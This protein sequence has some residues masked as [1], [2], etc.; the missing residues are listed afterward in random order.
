[1]SSLLRAPT[2]ETDAPA[3]RSLLPSTATPSLAPSVDQGGFGAYG[4][5]GLL[6]NAGV[7]EAIQ[8][9]RAPK[10]PKVDPV[11][12]DRK[13]AATELGDR[14]EVVADDHE[15]ERLSN[16]VTAAEYA[17]ICAV[18]SDV[19]LGRGD[20][21]IDASKYT[22]GKDQDAYK[23]GA[24]GDIASLLQTESGR[25]L[26]YA[27][28]DN[29]TQTDENGDPV[30][31][32]TTLTPLLND[33]GTVDK[34]NG[35]AAPDG[36]DSDAKVNRDGTL[37]PSAGTNVTIAYNPGVNVGDAYADYHEANPWLAG[38][39]SDVILMHEG[40]HALMM[41]QGMC[42]PRDVQKTDNKAN[43]KDPL[44][45]QDAR[46]KISRTEHQ[47]VGVGL[48]ANDP[49]TENAYRA[50][51]NNIADGGGVGLV[52]GDGELTRRDSY[53]PSAGAAAIAAPTADPFAEGSA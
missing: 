3:P 16:Q 25:A 28:H 31:K 11:A 50:E 7:M 39:R 29:A 14:F 40:N 35:Y 27:L 15:G 24:L 43:P 21:T 4:L 52:E 32:H 8:S 45:A 9:R 46:A 17:K 12:A 48:Y 51:R 20:L 38:F 6:G 36:W 23:A 30:H 44:M 47:A 1:M 49:M 19:R 13:K 37:S 22:S 10:T 2:P 34:T 33:D 41:T 42:D 5:Q 53:T 18:Y 26:I